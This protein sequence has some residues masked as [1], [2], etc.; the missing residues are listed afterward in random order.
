MINCVFFP[1]CIG[2]ISLL[3]PET[4][5]R[6]GDKRVFDDAEEYLLARSRYIELNP[7][8][9]DMMMHPAEYRWRSYRSDA[10]EESCALITPHETYSRLGTRQQAHA[11]LRMLWTKLM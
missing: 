4:A 11:A 10:H 6:V 9:A 8:S 1:A 5:K 2:N 7:V 3:L